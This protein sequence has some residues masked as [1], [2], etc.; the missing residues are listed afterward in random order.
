MT[1]ESKADNR[2]VEAIRFLKTIQPVIDDFPKKYR[3]QIPGWSH[4]DHIIENL[5]KATFS[6][7]DTE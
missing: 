7:L 6:F 2:I 4:V 5:E 1:Y 3:R